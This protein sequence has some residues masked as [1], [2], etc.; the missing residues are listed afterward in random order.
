MRAPR[1]SSMKDAAAPSRS[2]CQQSA[3]ARPSASANARASAAAAIWT[4]HSSWLTSFIRWPSPGEPPTS[5][6]LLAST[7]RSGRTRAT[8]PAGPDTMISRSPAAA[9][10][11]PP[12]TGASTTATPRP[13]RRPAAAAAASGPT[14]AMIMATVPPGIAAAAPPGPNRACSSWSGVATMMTTASARPAAAA[15]EPA[16][17]TPSAASRLASGVL[18]LAVE[19]GHDPPERSV[20]ADVAG[21]DDVGHADRPG[22][23]VD[24]PEHRD[25][26]GK[27]LAGHL[28]AADAQAVHRDVVRGD[29]A[30]G[31]DPGGLRAQRLADGAGQGG[32]DAAGDREAVRPVAA[33]GDGAAGEEQH[34]RPAQPVGDL[35]RRG[36]HHVVAAQDRGDVELDVGGGAPRAQRGNLPARLADVRSDHD[37]AVPAASPGGGMDLRAAQRRSGPDAA[38]RPHERRPGAEQERPAR[39]PRRSSPR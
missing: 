18:L 4:P 38:Q 36:R 21:E 2:T 32:G 13:A 31:D 12:E 19:Y 5:G 34:V 9:R 24:R 39:T 26:A 29:P 33:G 8:G 23:R 17:R 22:R 20:V 28:G 14:V 30:L 6:A 11:T 27:Q 3:A 1:S 16:L 25:H 15:A 10:C 35:P 37:Q 7:S